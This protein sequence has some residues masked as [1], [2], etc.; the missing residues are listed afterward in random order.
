MRS[1]SELERRRTTRKGRERQQVNATTEWSETARTQIQQHAA[2]AG[3]FT[4][5]EL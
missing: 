4:V 2:L 3:W 5:P 1:H